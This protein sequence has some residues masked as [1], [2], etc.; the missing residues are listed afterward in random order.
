MQYRNFIIAIFQ[1][2]SA[3][4][5]ALGHRTEVLTIRV[6]FHQIFCLPA[7]EITSYRFRPIGQLLNICCYNLSVSYLV[8]RLCYLCRGREVGNPVSYVLVAGPGPRLETG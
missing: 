4:S 7:S 1:N 8:T 3:L 5:A 6:I 2:A